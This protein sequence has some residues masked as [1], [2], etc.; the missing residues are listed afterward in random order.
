MPTPAP[1][2]KYNRLVAFPT[3]QWHGLVH[4]RYAPPARLRDARLTLNAFVVHP[5]LP[6]APEAPV[7]DVEGVLE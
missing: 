5:D 1:W 3:W 2:A 6:T 4:P 7:A